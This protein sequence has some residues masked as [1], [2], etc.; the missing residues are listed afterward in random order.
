MSLMAFQYATPAGV[1]G[2]VSRPLESFVDTV[3]MNSSTPF[4]AYGQFGTFDNT[5]KFIPVTGSTVATQLDGLLVRSVPSIAGNLTATFNQFTP[6]T[7]YVQGRMTRGYANVACTVGTPV[8]G[9]SVYVRIVANGAKAVGDIEA[10]ADVG[11]VGAAGTNTG[12]GTIGTVSATS[13]ANAGVYK[14]TMLTATTFEVV[15]PLNDRLGEGATGTA[16]SSDGVTFTITVGGTPMVAGDSFTVTV[17]DGNILVPKCEWASNGK[18]ANN[19]AEIYIK[20]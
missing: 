19:V 13:A 12:D 18:D 1:T 10:T 11:A 16:Y 8:K 9:G 6:S 3:E 14:I 2:S 4:L 5:G 17:T 20:G 15:N 7:D